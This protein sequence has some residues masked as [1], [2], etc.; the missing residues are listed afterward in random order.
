MDIDFLGRTSHQ[1]EK[2]VEQ[3]QDI[4]SIEMPDGLLFDH[5][6]RA[7]TI[8]EEA[9]YSGVRI[10]FSAF[11]DTAKIIDIGFG[12]IVY[13]MPEKHHL[14]TLLDL[15]APHLLCYSRESVIA[16]KFETMMKL[17]ALN[18]RM[19]DVYDIWF[20][21]RQYAFDGEKLQKAI[22]LAFQQRKTEYSTPIFF[23]GYFIEQKQS[24]WRAFKKR[25]GHIDHIPENL[26]EIVGF[27]EVF[28]NP[29]LLSLKKG[30]DFKRRW[31][32][33]GLWIT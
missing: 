9:D 25:L 29:I 10:Q 30:T 6:I 17:G 22:Q 15:P 2:I 32:P 20:L 8:T 26:V 18:S 12:D 19:K 16:E 5:K 27:L 28:L 1:K 4:L 7:D 23:S 11:L 21:S 14:P 33:E 24:Q 13:P 31:L 3:I